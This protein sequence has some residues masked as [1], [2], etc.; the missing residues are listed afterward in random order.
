MNPRGV[1][2][3]LEHPALS[4]LAGPRLAEARLTD[5]ERMGLVLQAA[6]LG[7]HLDLA[8]WHRTIDWSLATCVGGQL[9]VTAAP[10]VSSVFPQVDL[11]TLLH[12]LFGTPIAGRGEA[13]RAAR[14][15]A[16][17]WGQQLSPVPYDELVRDV[18][19]QADFLWQ[20]TSATARG[21]L[22]G[23]RH[24]DGEVA[25]WVAGPGAFRQRVLASSSSL[26][27]AVAL[28]RSAFARDLWS[29]TVGLASTDPLARAAALRR[30]GRLLSAAEELRGTPGVQARLL[31]SRCLF[32]AGDTVAAHTTLQAVAESEL[33]EAARWQW[34]A[35]RLA[36][37]RTFGNVAA[38]SAMRRGLSD[39]SDRIVD[40]GASTL[41]ATLLGAEICVALEE[42]E[43]ARARVAELGR[44]PLEELA[45]EGLERLAALEAWLADADSD[46]SGI[47][48]AW[49]LALRRARA[50]LPRAMAARAW[51]EIG[52][53]RQRQGRLADAERAFRHSLRRSRGCEGRRRDMEA[54]GAWLDT[55]LRRGRVL[56]IE[57]GLEAWV[58]YASTQ[59]PL[60]Q[61]LDPAA[62]TVRLDLAQG[63]AH[64]ALEAADRAI[65]A[66]AQRPDRVT[67]LQAMAARALGWLGRREQA[68]QRL[69]TGGEAGLQH[70][71]P[72]ERIAVLAQAG[73]GD[74][75][76]A[77]C[78]DSVV[79]ALWAQV[80]ASGPVLPER[81]SDLRRLERY[82]AARTVFDIVLFEPDLVPIYWRRRAA[83]DL[84][85]F[86][87]GQ[88]AERIESFEVGAWSA[89]EQFV[90][91]GTVDGAAI[92]R[93]FAQSGYGEVRLGLGDDSSRQLNAGIGGSE[94]LHAD[95][96]AGRLSLAAPLVDAPLRALFAVVVRQLGAGAMPTPPPDKEPIPHPSAVVEDAIVIR[97]VVGESDGLRAAMAKA[98]A[99]AGGEMPILLHGETG[100]GKELFARGVHDHSRRK[101][102]AF[103]A[104]NC[105]ALS[106][107][108]LLSDLF[109]HVRGSFTGAD[110]D[111]AGV[112]EAARGGT[113]F[114]DEIGD[115]PPTAQGMLLRVLQE[116]EV[117]RV[118]ES[119]AR[120]VDVRVVA[121]THRDLAALVK[122]GKFRQDLY[123]RLAVA[124]VELPPLR[125]RGD[126]VILL[127]QAFLERH[128]P[129]RR[130][131][132][133]ARAHLLGHRWPG[134]V[135]ELENVLAVSAALSADVI[136]PHHLEI[137][138]A[139]AVAASVRGDYHQQIEG[140]RRR[141]VEEAL[142]ATGGN[143]AEAAR[144]LGLTRQA[145]SYLS[146]Q[147]G[148][149]RRR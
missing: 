1:V 86:G 76:Y 17:L 131:S 42:P 134:N 51:L 7:S 54:L 97:N 96:P 127:A 105:A 109:G 55:R 41:E 9:H 21:H 15:L 140:F 94:L 46:P 50:S 147:M 112:F 146:Q 11:S 106:E 144:R 138:G 117:R 80:L 142:A 26:G 45:D 83:A 19:E 13:R 67:A 90:R 39:R 56:G 3:Q 145:L 43:G 115:L 65:E 4:E 148:L 103:V 44:L 35:L 8:G 63:R 31:R 113:V 12:Q 107:T 47:E 81:W 122:D 129:D 123:F 132:A 137:P 60:L 72:E 89:L 38:A 62:L 104:I 20:P 130:L 69:A 116:K 108:L 111:R 68:F 95:T 23:L 126:D 70:L 75:A 78:A 48:R 61:T 124:V 30:S 6:A 141:L 49:S 34:L 18:L 93:L 143:R 133:R 101:A 16:R 74:A 32:E 114:L 24:G 58:A 66:S 139:D 10:G 77:R 110:R 100:T 79:G 91:A 59:S 99:L 57:E 5:R 85:R 2:R 14:A 121:A 82:R 118:G 40:D 128:A 64:G 120:R 25:L 102:A 27:G 28:L 22:A 53:A 33:D 84:R 52:K 135:R 36:I 98:A 119:L 88:L 87:A 92:S 149:A 29:S 73:R 71:E 125:D 136:E 37:A